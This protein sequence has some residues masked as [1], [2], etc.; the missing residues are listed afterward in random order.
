M[1]VQRD[2][3]AG[4]VR[5]RVYV[6][7]DVNAGGVRGRMYA[8]MKAGLLLYGVQGPGGRSCTKARGL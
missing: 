7:R 8:R 1:Y 2:V 3:N 4:D 6:R 5:G